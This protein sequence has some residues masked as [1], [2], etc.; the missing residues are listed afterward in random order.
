MILLTYVPIRRGHFKL[1]A[2]GRAGDARR[3]RACVGSSNASGTSRSTCRAPVESSILKAAAQPVRGHSSKWNENDSSLTQSIPSRWSSVEPA[4]RFTDPIVCTVRQG[5]WDR[6]ISPA[7]LCSPRVAAS[8]STDDMK[9]FR[10]AKMPVA[11]GRFRVG[12]QKQNLAPERREAPLG[13]GS[14]LFM[15]VFGIV[16]AQFN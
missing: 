7:L 12:G 4:S 13:P 14:D 9:W 6:S 1:Y 3:P 2:S 16:E 8:N 5:V 11:G 15:C 10:I